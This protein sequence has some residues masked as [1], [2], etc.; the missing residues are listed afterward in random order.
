[1]KTR[2]FILII[3]FSVVLAFVLAVTAWL[4]VSTAFAEEQSRWQ[5]NFNAKVSEPQ[6]IATFEGC[7][8]LYRTIDYQTGKIIYVLTSC[9]A[10]A[11]G[12]AVTDIKQ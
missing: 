8:K 12:I 5:L 1:M 11:T 6:E 4:P 3:V 10:S 9:S 2:T 7:R